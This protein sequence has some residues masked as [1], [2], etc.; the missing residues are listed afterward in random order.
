MTPS[1]L[2]LSN[3]S[4]TCF[5]IQPCHAEMTKNQP[6]TQQPASTKKKADAPNHVSLLEQQKEFGICVETGGEGWFI[7]EV[8]YLNYIDN[9]S[10]SQLT[11]LYLATI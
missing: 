10:H 3:M 9:I 8:K 4:L 1:T 6:T 11:L 2:V 7:Q 5:C